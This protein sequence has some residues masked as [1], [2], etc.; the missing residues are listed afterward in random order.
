MKDRKPKPSNNNSA[1]DITGHPCFA[2]TYDRLLALPERYLLGRIRQAVV[3][4]A[5]GQVLEIG[6]GTGANL[7]YYNRSVRQITLT[8][9]DPYMLWQAA[10]KAKGLAHLRL[11]QCPAENLPFADGAFDTVVVTLALC[12]VADQAAAFAEMQRVLKPGGTVRFLEHVRSTSVWAARLQDRLTPLWCR[13]AAGCH[14]NRPTAET[15]Q[16]MGFEIVELQRKPLPLLPLIF[17][18][19]R[20]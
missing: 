5:S 9:P 7:H 20:R 1:I 15:M 11:V 4:P 3:G 6:A 14:L 8:E 18:I 17:G 13:C 10:E 16:T 12:T 2:L 19:A